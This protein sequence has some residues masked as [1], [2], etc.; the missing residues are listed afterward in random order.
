MQ[1]SATYQGNLGA[2][3]RGGYCRFVTGFSGGTVGSSRISPYLMPLQ[4]TACPALCSAQCLS[5]SI[6]GSVPT[7]K[8]GHHSLGARCGPVRE[9]T[10]FAAGHEPTMPDYGSPNW[11]NCAFTGMFYT[12]AMSG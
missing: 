5:G 4:L 7:L 10:Q 12:T 1:F 6:V 2:G 8:T 9:F 11:S 3:P